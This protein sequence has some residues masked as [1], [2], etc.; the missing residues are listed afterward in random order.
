ME[1]NDKNIS[2]SSKGIQMK[3][4]ISKLNMLH[5]HASLSS[6]SISK[7]WLREGRKRGSTNNSW[8][9][10]NQVSGQ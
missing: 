6:Y 9:K 4:N 2:F 7:G 8:V 3:Q 5:V 1:D 10:A